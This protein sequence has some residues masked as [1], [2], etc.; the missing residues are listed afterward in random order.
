M[1]SYRVPARTI[2]RLGRAML[3][4]GETSLLG[5]AAEVVGAAR[6][7]MRLSGHENVP[8][9]GPFVFVPNHCQRRGLWIGFPSALL[10]RVL[11]EKRPHAAPLH[12]AVVGE[13]RWAAGRLP[14][15]GTRWAYAE[16]ARC[17][18]MVT[19]P[20]REEDVAGRGQALRRLARLALP[21]PR[22]RGEPIG[23]YPEGE[24]GTSAAMVDALPGTGA[25]LALLGAAGVPSVPVGIAET[26]GG[27]EVRI[28]SP[29]IPQRRR[30]ADAD[31]LARVEVMS[32]IAALVPARMR[33]PHA[34]RV[35]E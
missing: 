14:I 17:Y 35:V 7:P 4:L 1:S 13:T 22:G 30:G 33:G 31:L 34:P 23:L 8:G 25:F 2:T 5:D 32:R 29:F 10:T 26:T 18:Q 28:G 27:L 20:A 19:L 24:H 11:A 3:R 12:W 21:P 15:P 6:P 16:V 9:A